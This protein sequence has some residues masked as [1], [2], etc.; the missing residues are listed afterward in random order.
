[1]LK[2]IIELL[3]AGFIIY[4]IFSVLYVTMMLISF[5]HS[6]ILHYVL[7]KYKKQKKNKK[8]D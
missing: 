1:M 8:S 7:K 4:A 6:I 3:I 5:F 2:T